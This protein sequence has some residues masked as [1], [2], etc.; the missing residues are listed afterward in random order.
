MAYAAWDCWNSTRKIGEN[1]NLIIKDK[2]EATLLLVHDERMHVKENMW[3]LNNDT[4]YHMCR[5][6]GKFIELDE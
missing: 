4:N 6:R 3:Y 5:D 1:V 2:K